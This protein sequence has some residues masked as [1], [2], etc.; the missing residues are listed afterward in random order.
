MRFNQHYLRKDT[1]HARLSAS[2]YSWLNYD[3][4]KLV[5]SIMAQ[6]ATEVG[7]K[8]HL[9]AKHM[10]EEGIRAEDIP[11]TFNMYV[12]DCIGFRMTAEVI[13]FV[14]EFCFGTADALSFRADTLRVFDYK[15]GVTV[16]SFKQLLIY[17]AM[18]C[19]EY[20]MNPFQIKIEM[21]IYQNNEIREEIADPDD[22]S[23]I[24][25]QI[26][27]ATKLIQKYLEED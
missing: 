11:Q 17:A 19:L 25:A 3:E 16:A 5:E 8:R 1:P 22:V 14:N 13:L 9:M 7:T 10:I 24:I 23:H 21:R 2:K 4:D 6:K 15:S 27:W 12:N 20:Q 26:N 18:F